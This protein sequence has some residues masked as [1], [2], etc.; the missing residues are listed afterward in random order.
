M[1]SFWG[2]DGGLL[3]RRTGTGSSLLRPSTGPV[4]EASLSGL[5]LGFRVMFRAVLALRA[6]FPE[7]ACRSIVEA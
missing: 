6:L 7:L 2:M 5:E 3:A 1:P 4:F